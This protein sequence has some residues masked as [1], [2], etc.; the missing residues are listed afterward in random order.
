MRNSTTPSAPICAGNDVCSPPSLLP[1]HRLA[2][3]QCVTFNAARGIFGFDGESSIGQIGFPPIQAAPSFPD[4]FPHLFGPGKK[5][6]CL[7]PCAIDQ[8]PYFRMTRDVAPKIKGHKPALIESRFF[9]ALKGDTGATRAAQGGARRS[10]ELCSF[11]R[12]QSCWFG[13]SPPVR[14]ARCCCRYCV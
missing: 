5:L 14:G 4:S 10:G 12:W 13:G 9:P 1:A 3:S 2:A 6:R 7:I 8:D 11:A